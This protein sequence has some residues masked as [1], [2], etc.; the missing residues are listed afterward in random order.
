MSTILDALA[1]A[2]QDEAA[3]TG[4]AGYGLP[5]DHSGPPRSPRKPSSGWKVAALVLG[6]VLLVV[7]GAGAT[8]AAVLLLYRTDPV[9]AD[10]SAAARPAASI[11]TRILGA[12]PGGGAL[13]SPEPDAA[14]AELLPSIELPTPVPL[15]QLGPAAGA[16]LPPPPVG[17]APAPAPPAIVAPEPAPLPA[18]A[19]GL[20]VG[21]ILY[22]ERIRIAVVN[23]MP[24]REGETWDD[25]TVLKITP[26]QVTVQR[27]G[28]RPVVLRPAGSS[29]VSGSVAP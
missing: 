7:A 6:G 23:G 26:Y 27:A 9:V 15:E 28:E 5:G 17:G 18:H 29:G 19:P 25:V 24:M 1:K 13:K 22:D 11:R 14:G 4:A 21:S 10:G 16:A 8:L 2:R 20:A 12:G 3:E